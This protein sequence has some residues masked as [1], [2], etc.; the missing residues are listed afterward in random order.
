MARSAELQL[1]L[2]DITVTNGDSAFR[3]DGPLL[4]TVSPNGDGFRDRVFVHFKL[5]A[6]AS[7]TVIVT[8]TDQRPYP[9][10]LV[11]GHFGSGRH[12][13]VWKPAPQVEPRTYL[14]HL[15]A[16]AGRRVVRYGA[17]HAEQ[18]RS[19]PTPVVRI[20]GVDA[21][22]TSDSYRPRSSAVLTISSDADSLTLKTFRDGP[23][24][25]WPNPTLVERGV[26]MSPA[27]T[28]P[29][30]RR[31]APRQLR[32]WV[33]DLTPGLYFEQMA[34]DD[35]RIG[36]APFIVRPPRWGTSRIA[37]VLPT[38][39]WQAYNFR[40]EDGNGWGDTWYATGSTDRLVRRNKPFLSRGVPPRFCAYDVEFQ[41][42]LESR[43]QTPD[44]LADSDLNRFRSGAQ[45]ASLYDLIV[46]P[47]HEEYVTPKVFRLVTTYRN[48]GGNLLFLS[49]NN[50]YW[51]TVVRRGR[52]RRTAH[53]RDVGH[54]ED[55]LVGARYAGNDR[56]NHQGAYVVRRSGRAAWLWAAT[57]LRSGSEFGTFGIE[58][59]RRGPRSPRGTLVVAVGKQRVGG[60]RAEMTYYETSPSAKVFDAGA[61][62][63]AGQAMEPPIRTILDNLW[64]RLSTP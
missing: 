35:G 36:Y 59:D 26:P 29:W 51:R 63:L 15:V 45:L 43:R 27:V 25:C 33:P 22:F 19:D 39:T 55:A 20:Q 61:F 54:P 30:H 49:A 46:F 16:R 37:V 58:I 3:G 18:A 2:E 17:D 1:T 56:G 42:W 41:K 23:E 9:L 50:F 4:T 34:A 6:A 8:R 28:V 52:L 12:M 53:W 13:L 57:A 62:T 60:H 5:R 11:Q 38:D 21:A 10:A 7:V 24:L 44:V 31:G 40:D 14:L 47:G 64:I 48:R 32:I